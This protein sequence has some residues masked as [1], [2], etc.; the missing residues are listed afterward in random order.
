MLIRP[1]GRF[2][3]ALDFAVELHQG[4][5]RKGTEI[6][7]AAHLMAVAA[8]VIQFGGTEDEAIAALLHDAAEDQGGEATLR[9]IRER[10]GGAVADVVA[11]CSDT[12]EQPKPP[13]RER[14]QRYIDHLGEKTFSAL[15][16]A[17][18]DKLDNARAIVFDLRR[19]G[20]GMMTRF[21][22]GADTPWY[23]REVTKALVRRCAE[24]A[25]AET[26]LLEVV[27]ELVHVVE[28]LER[29]AAG[30]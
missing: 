15:L 26:R 16:V 18:C 24:P 29:L 19:D 3:R 17:A 10:F 21:N 7:Y 5:T 11:A 13:W 23:Y 22:G 8:L 28:E 27:A 6:P 25:L 14:K 4:Q 12:F 20:P 2:K 9:R 1:D 30:H